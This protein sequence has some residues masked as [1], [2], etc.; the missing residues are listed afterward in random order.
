MPPKYILPQ[1]LARP[2]IE[3]TVF[4]VRFT[5]VTGDPARI[6]AVL[7]GALGTSY[8]R[9]EAVPTVHVPEYFRSAAPDPRY[10]PKL[11]LMGDGGTVYLGDSV[12]RLRLVG[13]YPG[14]EAVRAKLDGVLDALAVSKLAKDIER[15]SLKFVNVLRDPPPRQLEALRVDFRVNKEAV[16]EVGLHVRMEL[17]DERYRRVVEIQPG[18]D[19]PIIEGRRDL[20]GLMLALDVRR[21]LIGEEFWSQRA[22]VLENLHFELRALFFR[23]LTGD[24]V[25]QLGPIYRAAPEAEG[26]GA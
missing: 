7:R 9:S 12:V 25:T 3:E 24:S 23:L 1:E 16:P 17:S 19:G 2:P 6:F 18:A 10:E 22:D 21:D 5:P 11:K 4:E 20:H 15:I 13:E 14:W 26:S 8:P